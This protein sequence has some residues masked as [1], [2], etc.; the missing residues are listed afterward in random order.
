MPSAAA[1]VFLTALESTPAIDHEGYTKR[2]PQND[3][4]SVPNIMTATSAIMQL[5]ITVI[6][7]SR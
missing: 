2:R 3:P 1:S 5:T 6:T 4:N 7:M